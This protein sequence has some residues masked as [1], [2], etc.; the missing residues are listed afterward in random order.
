MPTTARTLH[1]TLALLTPFVFIAGIH[2]VRYATLTPSGVENVAARDRARYSAANFRKR[3]AVRARGLSER[4]AAAAASAESAIASATTSVT[5]R[6]VAAAASATTTVRAM[7]FGDKHGGGYA[8]S[9]EAA[10]RKVIAEAGLKASD[11]DVHGLGEVTTAEAFDAALPKGQAVWLTFSNAAYLH[12][13]QNWYLSVK[14]IGRHRQVVVAALDAPT[15]KAWRELKVPVL[16]Y[17]HFGDTSDFRGIGSDQARFRRMGAMKV[18]AFHQLLKLNRMVLVSDVDTV[19]TADPQPFLENLP[20]AVDIGVTSDCLS[21]EADENK[22]GRS[23]RFDPH[24]VWFCGHNPGNTFGA[25]FNTGVLFLKPTPDAIAFT[26]RWHAKLE[27]A[28]TDWHMED[29]RGFNMLVMDNFYP[30]VQSP[31][32]SDGT[33]VRA[34]NKTINLMPLP[35]RRFCSGHTYFVQQSARREQ[36]LN[37]HVTFTEGGIHGKLWRL[38]EAALWNL[39]PAGYFD[40]GRYLT[41]RAPEIPRPYP[42]ARIEPYDQCQRRRANGSPIDPVYH[43]WWSPG[44]AL[45]AAK[46]KCAQETKQYDDRN[47]DH[48]VTIDEAIAM[49]PRLQGHLKMAA[50][51]LVALR[52]GMSIAWLLNRTFVFPRFGFLCDRSE[53]PDIMPTCR[54]EN[55]DLEFP[56]EGPLN[57]MLNVHFMQGVEM[58]NGRY[59][60]LPYKE[61]SYLTNPRLSKSIRDSNATVI[62]SYSPEEAAKH[63]PR[64]EAAPL[65]YGGIAE[66]PRGATDVEVLKLLG[67]GSKFHQTATLYLDDGENVLG[68]FEDAEAGT[69]IRGLLDSKVLYGSWCCSRTNFHHPGATA[70][71]D[72]PP[73][74]PT[75][76][77][78]TKLRLARTGEDA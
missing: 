20:P 44:G 28:T 63:P 60:G 41:M 67:P 46:A 48:G 10:V 59:H 34:A 53:W 43:N 68:G 9:S 30:T 64:T 31:G 61:H 51:Y 35:A 25:T 78:A 23:K 75:G 13:A 57:F 3:M 18:A 69:Y 29:Q 76:R 73:S 42:P 54:L 39:H 65:N 6:A 50:R 11:S 45:V 36:C 5:E 33:V 58:G 70:F 26:S 56:F 15:L 17:A 19:W 52:D 8:L 1:K 62:F 14:A 72:K 55:S 74:L 47:K 24:G 38:Q 27:E 77:A 40:T 66:V 4:A 12:F 32:V 7:S 22:F 71:F 2:Y 49:A 37:V 16:D 21:R